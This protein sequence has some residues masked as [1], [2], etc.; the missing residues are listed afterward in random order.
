MAIVFGVNFAKISILQNIYI[1]AV[2]VYI[3][4]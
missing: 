1:E 4:R 3:V 2:D